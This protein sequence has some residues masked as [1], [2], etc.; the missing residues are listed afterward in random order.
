M[1]D[2]LNNKLK[3]MKHYNKTQL[4]KSLFGINICFA[5]IFIGI[6]MIMASCNSGNSHK[7]QYSNEEQYYYEYNSTV[8][9]EPDTISYDSTKG[10]GNSKDIIESEY[11]NED[12]ETS[13]SDPISKYY[14]EG[15]DA[16][17]EAGRAD[18]VEGWEYEQQFQF[19]SSCNYTGKKQ[20]DYVQGYEEGYEAGYNENKRNNGDNQW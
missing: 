9:S 1:F 3:Y 14:H 18:A 17:Y 19:D 6:L 7:P 12:D 20:E 16:G 11:S 8:V 13:G 5:L 10:E 4:N 15:Y 2:R